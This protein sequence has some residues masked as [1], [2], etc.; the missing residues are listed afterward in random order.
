VCVEDDRPVTDAH[1]VSS[2]M[3]A[4]DCHEVLREPSVGLVPNLVRYFVSSFTVLVPQLQLWHLHC[5]VSVPSVGD[6]HSQVP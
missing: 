2:D 5:L 6:V 1:S 4:I 3:D